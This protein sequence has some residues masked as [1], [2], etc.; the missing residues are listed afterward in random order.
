MKNLVLLIL[1]VLIVFALCSCSN[2]EE[3]YLKFTLK[4]D[5]TYS[6]VGTLPGEL[7]KEIVIPETYNGKPVTEIAECAFVQYHKLT[8]VV[9][10][11]SVTKIGNRAFFGCDALTD[12]TIPDGVKYIE[13]YTFYECR[14]LINLT[15]P[16]SVTAIGSHAFR[17]C[18]SLKSINIPDNVTAIGNASFESCRSL[19][20]ITIPGSVRTIGNN[21]F[22]GCDSLTSVVIPEG[23]TSIGSSVFGGCDNLANV[24]LPD[25]LTDIGDYVFS[26]CENLESVNIPNGV[27]SIG[28][29]MFEMCALTS[30]VIPESVTV[31]GEGAFRGC[32]RLTSIVIPD[33]VTVIEREA[34]Q[35][36]DSLISIM[37]PE[38]VIEI[39]EWAI[40]G[41]VVV[42]VATDEQPLGWD[43]HA[44]YY[45][46]CIIFGV[47]DV[48]VTDDG[49]VWGRKGDGVS[50]Y[51]YNGDAKEVNIPQIIDGVPV[52]GIMDKVFYYKNNITNITLPDS[53]EFIGESVFSTSASLRYNKFDNAY[54]LGNDNNPYLVLVKVDSSA[55]SCEINPNTKIIGSHAFDGS[56]LSN[57]E[58]PD[59]VISLGYRS[60]FSCTKLETLIIGSGVKHIDSYMLGADARLKSIHVDENNAYYKAVDGSLYSKDGTVLVRYATGSEESLFVIPDTVTTI[61]PLAFC[62]SK[63]LIEVIIGEGVT[64]I[65]ESAFA[66]CKALTKVFIPASVVTVAEDIFDLSENVTVYCESVSR[67]DGWNKEWNYHS[68]GNYYLPVVWGYIG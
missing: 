46:P 12:I 29:N 15:L 41:Q 47:D 21:A 37:I 4:D 9:I 50:I 63:T 68:T 28:A 49:L 53:I 59:S 3:L 67:P 11:D 55:T 54:Y 60:F 5:G 25:T 23:V 45:E 51:K 56:K 33:G 64:S 32:D 20:S 19:Q 7:L 14:S 1:T 13:S 48:G 16:D 26:W 62:G 44:F 18:N 57:I 31:I 52:V 24:S 2:S 66:S 34:F 8:R 42:G 43:E 6:V 39:G 10:P 30:I 17:N 58:I 65:G 38:S 61:A 40:D 27:T 22:W 35:H 36:C